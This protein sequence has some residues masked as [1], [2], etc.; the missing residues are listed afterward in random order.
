MK[1]KIYE[2]IRKVN[3]MNI[4]KY[5]KFIK[6]LED[7]Y[8]EQSFILFL[9]IQNHQNMYDM[10]FKVRFEDDLSNDVDYYY[11]NGNDAIF[12]SI[13]RAFAPLIQD[14]DSPSRYVDEDD[15]D[16]KIVYW[17]I[18]NDNMNYDIK[19]ELHDIFKDDYEE[20]KH[21]INDSIKES[22]QEIFKMFNLEL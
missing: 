20:K 14:E 3:I 19:R 11:F 18:N 15:P 2:T 16:D 13:L 9:P 7:E 12:P 1:Q 22:T 8:K 10:K 6:N 21:K 5:K 17:V 4:D